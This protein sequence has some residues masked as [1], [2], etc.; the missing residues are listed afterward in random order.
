MS[1]TKQ[2]IL[3]VAVLSICCSSLLTLA[4]T[5]LKEYQLR[6]VA[7]DKKINILKSVRLIDE[8]RSLS[9][10]IMKKSI[11]KSFGDISTTTFKTNLL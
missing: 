1:N 4:S 6:N 5:G 9:P 3:F 7:L 2:S 8:R 10:D 11:L